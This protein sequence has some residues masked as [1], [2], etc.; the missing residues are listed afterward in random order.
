MQGNLPLLYS[1]KTLPPIQGLYI[2]LKM[3]ELTPVV[4]S[5]LHRQPFWRLH[6]DLKADAGSYDLLQHAQALL[7]IQR[8]PL[9]RF[10]LCIGI[11]CAP[12]LQ[13]IWQ[14]LDLWV[15]LHLRL[16][17]R[18][19][20]HN[21]QLLPSSP[22]LRISIDMCFKAEPVLLR[23]DAVTS[24]PGSVRMTLRPVQPGCV[25]AVSGCSSQMPFQGSKEPWQFC[26]HGEV[27]VVGLP[28][29]MRCTKAT[30]L[31]QNKAAA[32]AGWTEDR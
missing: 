30:Y 19:S 24:R 11:V 28:P 2:K 27:K 29:S 7:Q 18:V 9:H 16:M 6:V 3:S 4:L 13:Q 32:V 31:L 8:L 12:A 10:T 1:R 21:L 25:L 20:V 22:R 5:W 17:N 23:W 15:P 26:V 14:K